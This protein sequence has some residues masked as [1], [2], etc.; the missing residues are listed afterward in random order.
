MGLDERLRRQVIEEYVRDYTYGVCSAIRDLLGDEQFAKQFGASN[1]EEAMR[2]CIEA[3]EDNA[4][5]YAE[6]WVEIW[7]RRMAEVFLTT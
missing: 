3:A 6:K 5:R 7:P 2:K 1:P 4:R